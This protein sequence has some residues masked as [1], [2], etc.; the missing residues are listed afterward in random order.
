MIL[1]YVSSRCKYCDELLQL[2]KKIKHKVINI[3]NEEYPDFLPGVPTVVDGTNVFCGDAAYN[4]IESL[5]QTKLRA[6]P[7]HIPE[8]SQKEPVRPEE[9]PPVQ[10]DTVQSKSLSKNIGSKKAGTGNSLD[11]AF[12]VTTFVE[13]DDKVYSQNVD[14]RLAEMLASRR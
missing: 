8:I 6:V 13:K 9:R 5:S 7:R 12:N 10:T 4:F 3:D 2:M 14:K 11:T 1:V